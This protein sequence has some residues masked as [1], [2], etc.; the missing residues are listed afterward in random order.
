MSALRDRQ[1][2]PFRFSHN[3]AVDAFVWHVT[4]VA[5]HSNNCLTFD[6]TWLSVRAVADD[7]WEGGNRRHGRE[8][9]R[10]NI[11]SCI[12]HMHAFP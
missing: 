12:L 11:Q 2:L 1:L 3:W 4:N 9:M 5:M 7:A 8:P 6:R 10:T